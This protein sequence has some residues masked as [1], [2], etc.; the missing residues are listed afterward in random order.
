[1]SAKLFYGKVVIVTGAGQGIGFEIC[2]Q[3]CLQGAAGNVREV[4]G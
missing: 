1:M 3:L 2:K 4:E